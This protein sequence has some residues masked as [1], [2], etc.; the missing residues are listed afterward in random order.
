MQTAEGSGVIV[1]AETP[2]PDIST[3]SAGRLKSNDSSRG[4]VSVRV[5]AP[6]VMSTSQS[7]EIAEGNW[8]SLTVFI[9]FFC[10]D[11]GGLT[12]QL[13]ALHGGNETPETRNDFPQDAEDYE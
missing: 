12:F 4:I 6:I 9:E 11:F 8:M 10:Y 3:E 13:F 5:T 7:P 1:K 2:G